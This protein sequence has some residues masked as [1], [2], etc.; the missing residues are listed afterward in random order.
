MPYRLRAVKVG[1]A[2]LEGDFDD[3]AAR[4]LG[5]QQLDLLRHLT[6]PTQGRPDPFYR[7]GGNPPHPTA[8]VIFDR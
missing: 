4:V 6:H 2:P 8:M 7:S 3:L 5:R 1:A